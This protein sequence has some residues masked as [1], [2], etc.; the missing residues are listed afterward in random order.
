MTVL[1]FAKVRSLFLALLNNH[2]LSHNNRILT[3][4]ASRPIALSS[5]LQK[6]MQKSSF[7]ALSLPMQYTNSGA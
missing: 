7:A 2:P 3:D 4:N 5:C 1:T 6:M